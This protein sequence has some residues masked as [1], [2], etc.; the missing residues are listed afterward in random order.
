MIN[1]NVII[2]LFAGI[3]FVIY[4]I[5]SFSSQKMVLEFKRWGL[6]KKRKIIAVSQFFCGVL[7]CLGLISKTILFISS[8]FLVIMMLTAVYV[9]I[10][11]KDN[12][13]EILPAISYL[14][15]GLLIFKETLKIF[16]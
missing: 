7:L 13:S 8:S 14:L 6:E 10:K 5:N 16:Y 11:V 4:G 1:L 12:I 3:S 2:I 15:I 9:R